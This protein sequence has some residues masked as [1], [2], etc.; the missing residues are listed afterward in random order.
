MLG[1]AKDEQMR[2][3]CHTG[4]GIR[5]H[6]RLLRT[7]SRQNQ[8]CTV[9]PFGSKWAQVPEFLHPEKHVPTQSQLYPTC[10]KAPFVP[11]RDETPRSVL[12]SRK[13]NCGSLNYLGGKLL[14]CFSHLLCQQQ[15]P[16]CYS[17]S[18]N[19]VPTRPLVADDCFC[20]IYLSKRK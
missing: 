15:L 20:N 5:R 8:A 9:L 1:T 2:D 19:P 10:R 12:T 14:T 3:I 18:G 16:S 17:G 7:P 13:G 11:C 6:E 4:G